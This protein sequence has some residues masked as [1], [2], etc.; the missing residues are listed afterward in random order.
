MIFEDFTREVDEELAVKNSELK[1][2]NAEILSLNKEIFVLKMI[3][4]SLKMKW[5][6]LEKDKNFKRDVNKKLQTKIKHFLSSEAIIES[7]E[8][9]MIRIGICQFNLTS[10]KWHSKNCTEY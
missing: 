10:K 9:L 4:L 7:E 6:R 3:K 8:F 1:R 2:K 5:K